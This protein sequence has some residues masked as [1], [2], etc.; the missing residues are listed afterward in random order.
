MI[1]TLYKWLLIIRDRIIFWYYRTEAEQ[2]HKSDNMR[3]WV[4]RTEEG[5][6]VVNKYQINESN[7][8]LPKAERADIKKLLEN[9]LYRTK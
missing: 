7:R 4:I 1:R 2:K 9:A 6:Q 8:K 5:I 3:Y